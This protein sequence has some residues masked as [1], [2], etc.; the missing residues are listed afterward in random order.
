MIINPYV[1][2]AAGAGG[3]AWNP[4][5]KGTLITLTNSNLTATG[6]GSGNTCVRG[7]AHHTAGKYYYELTVNAIAGTNYPRFG[8]GD[9]AVPLTGNGSGAGLVMAVIQV[10]PAFT[11]VGNSA[12]AS[13]VT[14]V[15]NDIMQFAVDLTASKIWFGKNNTWILSGNPAAG[16][17]ESRLLTAGADYYPFGCCQGTAQITARFASASWTYAAP[18]GFLEW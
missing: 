3:T 12:I 6:S 5:D 2:A 11:F 13:G 14:Y 8:V 17:N 1:F 18:S 4:A 7:V 15:V 9:S 10:S 16:T